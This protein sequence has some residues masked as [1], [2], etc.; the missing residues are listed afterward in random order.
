MM[1]T[2]D[3]T[4]ILKR[5]GW[6]PYRDNVGD[7]FAHYHLPDR[8]VGIGYGVKNY[9]ESGKEFL[10]SADLT[11]AAYCLAREY[12]RGE[13]SQRKYGDVLFYA[14]ED[15]NV[16]APDLSES[17]IT[18]ALN[19]VIAWAQAQDIE[20]KLCEKAANHS[21]VAQALLGDMEA[22]RSDR[23]TPKLSVPEF[24]DYKTMTSDDRLLF[25][26][27][28]YKNGELDDIL[29]RKKPKQ[30]SISLTAAMRVLKT[31]GWFS[32]EP[33]KMWLILPDRFIQF[34][35]GFIRLHDNYNV[36]IEAEISNEMISVAC[37]CIHFS[38]EYWCV[39]P[40]GLYNSFNTIGGGIFSGFGKGID[41]CV[42][43]LD[44]QELIKISELIIQ[45]ARAQ[46][47]QA[48]IESKTRV[49]KYSYNIDIVWHL[50]CLALTGQID[51]LKSYQNFLE[52]GTISEIL[53]DS[54]VER[55]INQAVQF[56]E[57][58]LKILNERKA[59]DD[60]LSLQDLSFLNTVSEDLKRMDWTVYRDKNY[61]CNAYFIK[62]DRII[63]I[64][65][66]LDK[67]GETPFVTFKVSLST[68]GF[69]TAY[70]SIFINTPQYTVLKESEE[71]Y[72][73]SSTELDEGKLKQ[74]CADI[75]EWA[76]RQNVNQIIYDYAA[77]PTNSEYDLI[78]RHFIALILIGDV[79][80]LKF[81]K[82]NFRKGNSLG[83]V[84]GITKYTIDNAL[85]L[86]RGCR[87]GFPKNA[88]IL[89][90][91]P[92][93]AS[94]AS[95]T[96][97][98]EVDEAD[99]TDDRL[100]MESAHALLKSLGW[101]TEKINE[102]DH[103]AS[104]QLADR[105]VDILYNDK[106]AKDCPQFDSAF[107]I[108][109]GILAS[110]CKFIDPTHTEDIPDIQLNFEAKGLEIFEPEVT[111]DRLTQALDDAL[112]WSVTAIDLSE[113][114][115]SDY[116][117]APWQQDVTDKRDNTDDALLHLGALALLGDV[118]TLHSY[119]Q[120]FATGDHLGFDE[121]I[122]Q[123][124]LERAI[125]LAKEVAKSK[126]VSY[127]LIERVAKGFENHSELSNEE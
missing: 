46:D 111:A 16:K 121:S 106:I 112:E 32:T 3:V 95:K 103:M 70:R 66:D 72:A 107:L 1:Q 83:F 14:K 21:A 40:R 59:I 60:R 28:A 85:T 55:Y 96:T 61:N 75:L 19:K 93:I 31:Q 98:V 80:K 65:Y 74:I 15:F 115:R 62:K 88:P 117:L 52:A 99:D 113:R 34:D 89:S 41:I 36:R 58:Y 39:S 5:L 90:L 57:E 108:S 43:T 87:A 6:E 82:E 94:V 50:A 12:S 73:V 24:A 20:Q 49:Q 44:E 124:H 118:E 51:V 22:L 27:Q 78:I 79:E 116:G 26:A 7:T 100:T 53:D 29:T 84:E 54:E 119:Q 48:S 47:L 35:F 102:N 9:G 109:T 122:Q 2:K 67:N 38:E 114:L 120:S 97:S 64:V 110:A 8:I 92:Q 105:E 11:T 125:A 18:T 123:L 76:D 13:K 71:V 25:F 63:N 126:Q 127:A 104:Y 86:A 69:S 101:S 42:E 33:G 81:Y 23:S 45:W 4:E 17:H 30:C 10:L 68:L 77:L 56:A 91:D 37:N